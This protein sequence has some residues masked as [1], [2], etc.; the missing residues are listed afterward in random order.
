MVNALHS[1]NL[2]HPA[3]FVL[4]NLEFNKTI[5]HAGDTGL[6]SDMKLI[7]EE[8]IDI[9]MLPIGDR[10]TMGIKDALK[11]VDLIKPKI[12]IPIHYNTFPA[13]S[14]NPEDFKRQCS[15]RVEIF[16]PSEEKEM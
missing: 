10:Y 15:V 14:A 5:Y 9:A 2:G 6:F 1:S 16:Q 4:K 11:A 12:V 3:G 7:G 8:G 13:I